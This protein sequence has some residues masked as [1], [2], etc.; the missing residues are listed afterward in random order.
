MRVDII[1]LLFAGFK[2]MVLVTTSPMG[3]LAARLPL[4]N[5]LTNHVYLLLA[6]TMAI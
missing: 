1:E 5:I 3:W 6:V 2:P 4:P